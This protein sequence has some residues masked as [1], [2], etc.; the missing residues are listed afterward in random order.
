[1]QINLISD[2]HFRTDGLAEANRDADVFVCLGDLI[3]FLDY[4]DPAEG[5]FANLFG[6]ANSARYIEMRRRF[7]FDEAR[8]FSRELFESIGAEPW[9]AI[10]EQV[11]AQYAKL[12]AAMPGGLMTYGNVDLPVMW[13]EYVRSDQQV[14]DGETVEID[15]LRVGFVGGGLQ[16]PYRTPFEISAED[17]QRKVDQLGE[18]DVLCTHIPPAVPEICYDVVA[19]RLERGSTALLRY[20]EEVQP[21]YAVHG[22]VHQPLASRT[23]IGR[24]EVVNVGHFRSLGQPY[25]L[26]VN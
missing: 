7:K 6:A 20:I 25:R 4:D 11:A 17:F 19:R 15:G 23:T 16:T 24:T 18:V 8:A 10:S 2:V 26:I 1:M 22:H 3:L 9:Q 14:L 12:F 13:P 21:R 5:I